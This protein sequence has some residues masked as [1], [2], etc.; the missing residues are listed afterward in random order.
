M[1]LE[2]RFNKAVDY[3]RNGPP[4]PDSSNDEKLSFYKYYKQATV[5]DVSGTQPWAVQLEPRAKWDA[6]NSVKGMSREQAMQSYIDTLS[7]SCNWE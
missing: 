5:G 1:S 4:R 6:W 2:G 7:A 3:V